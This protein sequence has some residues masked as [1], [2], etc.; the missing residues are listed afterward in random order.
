LDFSL[1]GILTRISTVLSRNNIS[2]FVVST[3]DTDYILVMEP[4]AEKA[5]KELIK[6]GYKVSNA[7]K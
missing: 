3:F 7:S 4:D 6:D 5:V 2:I 1:I